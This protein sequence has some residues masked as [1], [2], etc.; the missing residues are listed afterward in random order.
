MMI[1]NL[2]K[3]M[4]YVGFVC[5]FFL[6]IVLLFLSV[7][8]QYFK[9]AMDECDTDKEIIIYSIPFLPALI[10]IYEVLKRIYLAYKRTW[11]S[12]IKKVAQKPKSR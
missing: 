5:I 9:L 6:A 11:L 2:I 1:I 10:E 8:H 12:R 4:F 3:E 7:L